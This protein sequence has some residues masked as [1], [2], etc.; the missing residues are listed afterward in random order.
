MGVAEGRWAWSGPEGGEKTRPEGEVGG[1][2]G[3]VKDPESW[4]CRGS[5]GRRRRA[6]SGGKA[7]RNRSGR[8]SCGP[9]RKGAV[10]AQLGA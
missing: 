9:G 4:P 2:W 5:P 8:G 1:D 3:L 6:A 7:P 10:A